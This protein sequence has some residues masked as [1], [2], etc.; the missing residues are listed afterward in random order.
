M[1]RISEFLASFSKRVSFLVI[2]NFFRPKLT[3]FTIL[4]LYMAR[5]MW[6]TTALIWEISIASWTL[7]EKF[8][9]S[10]FPIYYCLCNWIGEHGI[11]KLKK[12]FASNREK[13][14]QKHA[15]KDINEMEWNKMD[16][17]IFQQW[18]CVNAIYF[19]PRTT[20]RMKNN[21]SSTRGLSLEISVLSRARAQLLNMPYLGT[22][23]RVP[24]GENV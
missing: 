3:I 8:H 11:T 9:I 20:Y 21:K 23:L 24:H 18:A 4:R 19:C 14:T 6:K 17:L 2:C 15:Q 10:A 13:T 16:Y 7:V 12:I 5:K 1:V 22:H